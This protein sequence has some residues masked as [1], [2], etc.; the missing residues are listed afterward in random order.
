MPET[1]TNK[2]PWQGTVLA[3]LH[4]IGLIFLGLFLPFALI[5]GVIGGMLTFVEEV[6]PSLAMSVGGGGLALFLVLLAFFI[7]GIFITRG[8]FKGKRWVIIVSL[9]LSAMG[10]F[11]L[12]FNF[13]LFSALLMALFVY[14]EI[15]CLL[16]PFY[17]SKK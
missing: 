12:A 14:L 17:N 2:R 16:H 15:A 8:I 5:I 7:L 4:I 6:N 9:I 3:I 13:E 11:Q 1:K 10:V